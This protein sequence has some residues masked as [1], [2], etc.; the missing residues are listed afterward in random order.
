MSEPRKPQPEEDLLEFLGGI[1]E[2]NEDSKDGDFPDFLANGGMDKIDVDAAKE[3]DLPPGK[4]PVK[5]AR[6]E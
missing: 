4:H 2:L 6:S 5:E 1:D 3:P